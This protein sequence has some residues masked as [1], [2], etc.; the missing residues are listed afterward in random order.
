MARPEESLGSRAT[1][2][3]VR[4]TS[5]HPPTSFNTLEVGIDDL[6]KLAGR[7]WGNGSDGST[8]WTTSGSLPAGHRPVERYAVVPSRKAPRYLL[9][10][11]SR[12]AV[13]SAFSRYLATP[14]RLGRVKGRTLAA[15]WASGLGQLVLRDRL[16]VAVPDGLPA[17]VMAENLLLTHLAE[18]LG[19][20]DLVAAWSVRPA[21][22][23]AKPNARLLDRRG[24]MVGYLKLGWSPTSQELV[25][26]E[27]R[28]LEE[29]DGRVG[30]VETPRVLVCGSW[31]DQTF[32]VTS[33][34]APLRPMTAP[35]ET[36]SQILLA[37]ARSGAVEEGPLTKSTWFSDVEA[38]LDACEPSEP[39]IVAL[40]RRLLHHVAEED[41]WLEHG[42]WHG[43]LVPWNLGLRHKRLVAWDWEYSSDAVPVGFDLLHWH[44]QTALSAPGATLQAGIRSAAAAAGSLATL[45]VASEAAGQVVDCYLVELL[46]RA[47]GLAVSGAGWNPKVRHSLETAVRSRLG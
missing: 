2:E 41:P 38:R 32:L 21:M 19:V 25:R 37:I 12:R 35:P 45:G 39:D 22:P 24:T 17:A 9:P 27:T 40:L 10:L 46:T 26:N 31:S 4:A 18:L 29:L 47:T 43:D 6:Y 13:S 5:S 8:V 20:D 16:T 44:L 15:V 11:G 7:V 34:L 36:R 42:R 1:D 33:P 23:N 3:A 14:T 28:V 30:D